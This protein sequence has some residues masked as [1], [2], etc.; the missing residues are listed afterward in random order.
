MTTF[1]IG[2]TEFLLDG[3]P[4]QVLAGAI[5]YFRIHPDQWRDRIRKAKAMGL[6]TIETYVPWNAHAPVRGQFQVGGGLDLGRFLDLVA[7]EGMYAMVRPGPFICAEWDNG[8]LPVWLTGD[9]TVTVR[10]SEP[11]YLA[12]VAEYL[13]QVLPIVATRQVARGGP[14]LMVQVENEY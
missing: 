5:H 4:F 13:G 11:N 14:V 6:N 12:A 7:A 10:S 9:P 3:Q 8:G 1:E 2:E